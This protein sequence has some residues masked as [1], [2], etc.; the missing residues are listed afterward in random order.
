[1]GI[2]IIKQS[3][4]LQG[5]EAQG[6]VGRPLGEA[7]AQMCGVDVALAGA[8]SNDCGIWE[9]T[10]GRFRRQ[11]DNAEVMHILSGACTFTPEGGEP[12][13][14][15]AGDTLFFPSHTVGVWEISETLRKVYVVFALP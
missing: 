6:P 2:R 8:G 7:V 13:Q 9:C 4:D 11:I 5:L 15:A 12:L 3:K 14:I 1:M 10:P